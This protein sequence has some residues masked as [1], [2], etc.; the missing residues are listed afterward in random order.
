[1]KRSELIPNKTRKEV[2]DRSGGLCECIH[3][4]GQRCPNPAGSKHHVK[5]RSRGGSNDASNI[6]DVCIWCDDKI[7]RHFWE[8][9]NRWTLK[10]RQK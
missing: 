6:I 3:N 2:T 1:M 5:F 9:E 4:N 10:L 8:E 7:H